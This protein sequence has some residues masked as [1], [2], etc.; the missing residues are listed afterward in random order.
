MIDRHTELNV[1]RETLEKLEIFADLLIKWNPKINLVG[2]S[3]INDLWNRHVRDS[4][5]ICE[6][7]DENVAHWADFGSGGGFPGLVVAILGSESKNPAKTTLVESDQRKAAFLRTVIRETEISANVIVNRIET[8]PALGVDVVSARALADL[9]A[10]LGFADLHMQHSGTAIFPKGKKWKSEVELARAS[11]NFTYE[12][13]QSIT[14]PEAV[15]L[16]IRG[17]TRV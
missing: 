14:E 8:V 13:I 16:K 2:K 6:I 7:L 12:A 3:T 1:S 17:I 9:P 4:I 5:Q 11:W 10:L 15:V